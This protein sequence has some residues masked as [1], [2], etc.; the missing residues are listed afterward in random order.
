MR[1]HVSAGFCQGPGQLLIQHRSHFHRWFPREFIERY[2]PEA[3]ALLAENSPESVL[4]GRKIGG[5]V[6][7]GKN[8]VRVVFPCK[9][10]TRDN[11]ENILM[12]LHENAETFVERIKKLDFTVPE[13]VRYESC[14]GCGYRTLCRN[15]YRGN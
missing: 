13:E 9:N 2:H 3:P 10:G 11:Y 6:F 5:G 14:L 12:I 4:N 8:S 15:T 7:V 1:L